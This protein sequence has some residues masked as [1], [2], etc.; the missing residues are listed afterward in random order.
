MIP[1]AA[2]AAR[3][4]VLIP[5][6]QPGATLPGLV[7]ELA[8]SGELAGIIVVD[9]GSGPE[10]DAVFR[11]LAAIGGVWMWLVRRSQ[12]EPLLFDAGAATGLVLAQLVVDVSRIEGESQELEKNALAGGLWSDEHS[13]IAK[14][15]VCQLDLA[16][17]LQFKGL[18]VH[19][20]PSTVLASR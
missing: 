8:A 13:Q 14:R 20:R 2:E 17:P 18:D 5:A 9:D 6:Y 7:R 4:V 11:E 10:Y 12:A 3:P 1:S 16:Y 15:D 19:V